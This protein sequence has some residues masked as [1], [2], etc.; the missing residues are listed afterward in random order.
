M[1]PHTDPIYETIDDE[2]GADANARAAEALGLL[3]RWIL[4]GSGIDS[5]DRS[6]PGGANNVPDP[7]HV[8]AS[9]FL[10]V[11]LTVRPELLQAQVLRKLGREARVSFW[12]LSKDC[13]DAEKTFGRIAPERG[14]ATR[15]SVVGLASLS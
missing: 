13:R 14:R 7:R 11:V 8:I 12:R 15:P 4:D 9:R 10:A 1:Q 2:P 5:R 6:G 3:M